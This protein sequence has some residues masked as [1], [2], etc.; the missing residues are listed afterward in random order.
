M[1][2]FVCGVAAELWADTPEDAMWRAINAQKDSVWRALWSHCVVGTRGADP[3]A[4]EPNDAGSECRVGKGDPAVILAGFVLSVPH[5][6][7][8]AGDAGAG[9]RDASPCPLL[10]SGA[11]TAPLRYLCV[12]LGSGSRC[13]A[14]RG[15]PAES[16]A[17]D[18]VLR[19]LTLRDGHAEVMARRGFIAFLLDLVEAAGDGGC[20]IP[21]LLSAGQG[22][23][24]RDGVRVHLVCTRWMC[25][26]LAA[27]AGGA[28]RSG[29]LLLRTGC[30]CWLSPALRRQAEDEGK[31]SHVNALL[32]SC[33]EAHGHLVAAHHSPLDDAADYAVCSRVKPGKGRPN[34]S[35][36]C[37]DKV[38]RWS[39]LGL[40]GRRRS[41]LFPV[42]L[43]LSSVHVLHRTEAPLTE[44]VVEATRTRAQEV[45]SWRTRAWW[46]EMSASAVSQV[47]PDFFL[48]DTATAAGL[49]GA[50]ESNASDSGG[51]DS[52]YSRCR[53]LTVHHRGS[54]A[55]APLP[56]PPRRRVRTDSD[57]D[58]DADA[59]PEAV[60][61]AVHCDWCAADTR[62]GF[63]GLVLN[64]K[65]GLP[66][67]MTLRAAVQRARRSIMGNETPVTDEMNTPAVAARVV[68]AM[69]RQCPL[70]RPWMAHR[71]AALLRT[72]AAR[73]CIAHGLAGEVDVSTPESDDVSVLPA[74]A[75]LLPM[76]ALAHQRHVATRERD[77]SDALFL[78]SSAGKE[79]SQCGS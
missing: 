22:W 74:S 56:R 54:S 24:L 72:P 28:G 31:G 7:C 6:T 17:E 39:V 79:R 64:T 59:P 21:F 12:S 15:A 43:R 68:E 33:V 66:Q 16:A 34:L 47:T 11:Q 44:A 57:D 50:S 27:V 71:L 77:V 4:R 69:W 62:T 3:Q 51:V 35:M 45:M 75:R 42:P 65:A 26:A 19:A 10:S 46:P 8:S 55:A 60:G 25:G 73:A 53:W 48:F 38:W 23:V 20:P 9:C 14:A 61:G 76:H 18:G 1:T 49:R 40:Q 70:S 58:A 32:S 13:L 30:G 67:G 52:S 36:S 63:N 2:G 41:A 78:W 37:S 29:R 5:S